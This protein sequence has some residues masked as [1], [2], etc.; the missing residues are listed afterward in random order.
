AD[1]SRLGGA[2]I[3][4]E[5]GIFTG[6]AKPQTLG[7]IATTDQLPS[8]DTDLQAPNPWPAFTHAP[9][10]KAVRG[11]L[12][13]TGLLSV[14]VRPLSGNFL[15]PA[16]LVLSN[17]SGQSLLVYLPEVSGATPQGVTLLVADDGSTYFA[18]TDPAL[19]LSAV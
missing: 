8:V 12:P 15:P 17:R 5:A 7:G 9:S 4:V 10:K 19:Q 13:D 14:Q 18:P 2:S 1:P 3:L 11:Q 6:A 16:E